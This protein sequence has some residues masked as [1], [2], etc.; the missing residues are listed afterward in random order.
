MNLTASDVKPFVPAQ[1]FEESLRFYQALGWATNWVTGDRG[2]AELELGGSRF[3]LHNYYQKDWAEN[4]MLQVIVEDAAA[5]YERA[6]TVVEEGGF[7]GA[8]L[9]RPRVEPYGALVVHLIDPAGVLLHFTQFH[10]R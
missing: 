3:L 7:S 10:G 6:R 1:D 2:L 4:F 8:R 9:R 5:W